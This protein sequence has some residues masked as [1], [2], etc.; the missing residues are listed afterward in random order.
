MGKDSEFEKI[1][2]PRIDE[3]YTEM[4]GGKN[5]IKEIRRPNW[6]LKTPSKDEKER[7][8]LDQHLG[9]DTELIL[10]DGT[11]MTFQEK[12]R[13]YSKKRTSCDFT[14]E[15]FNK[16]ETG[17][18]GEFFKLKASWYFVGFATGAPKI[19][20]TDYEHFY[21]LNIPALRLGIKRE[22]DVKTMIDLGWL[23]DND[24]GGDANFFAIPFSEIQK[25]I[26]ECIYYHS[27][28]NW[29]KNKH[30]QI[31][32]SDFKCVSLY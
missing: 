22:W 21:I 30:E 6:D 26:P 1:M 18:P 24:D 23:H 12:S 2:Q 9:I 20:D 13:R 15:Y 27:K 14:L 19:K 5:G 17:E 3:I 25:K 11:P 16:P 28:G 4:F 7:R 32:S 8:Y 29:Y 31:C 10:D